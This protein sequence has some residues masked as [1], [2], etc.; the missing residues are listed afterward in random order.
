[1]NNF[2]EWI[3][4]SLLLGLGILGNFIGLIVFL[5]KRSKNF[6]P[7]RI[8]IALSV[9]DSSFLAYSV[10]SNFL[11]FG[12]ISFKKSY[13]TACKI[14]N[15][16]GY[17]LSPISSWLLVFISLHRFVSIA[18]RNQKLINKP[19]F[20][21]GVIIAILV[22]NLMLYAPILFF[23]ALVSNTRYNDTI[24]L[25]HE[26]NRFL[27]MTIIDLVNAV[28]LPFIL[29]LIL[30]LLLI[31]TIINSKL[32]IIRMTNNNEKKQAEKKYSIRY[33]IDFF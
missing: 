4:R 16:I 21:I 3:L 2:S 15:Y 29:M 26:P 28:L 6:P 8:F 13:D 10:I 22:F 19:L 23:S 32:R 14:N 27:L 24:C 30:S 5:R 20:Q 12:N 25:Y 31:R 1:M 18:F 9:V 17:F 33:I 11:I 7:R